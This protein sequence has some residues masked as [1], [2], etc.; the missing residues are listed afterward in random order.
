[1]GG[2][3][4]NNG[5]NGNDQNQNKNKG[6]GGGGGG[7]RGVQFTADCD[8]YSPQT[9]GQ[10]VQGALIT[11]LVGAVGAVACAGFTK[12]F[13]IVLNK[14][15]GRKPRPLFPD[16]VLP[17]QPGQVNL[18]RE[19]HGLVDTNPDQARQLIAAVSARLGTSP[20]LEAAITAPVT[21]PATTPAV[22]PVE[23]PQPAVEQK[24]NGKG[25]GNNNGGKKN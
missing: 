12:L 24:P 9:L 1:M 19:L 20:E 18:K 14:F 5:G 7:K 2:N 13:D 22:I 8:P 11:G 25:N 10:N 3:N 6:Q 23:T 21:A 15:T 17:S 4:N 16:A